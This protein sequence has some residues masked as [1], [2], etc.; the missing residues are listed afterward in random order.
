[1][2]I[3]AG[4]VLQSVACGSFDTRAPLASLDYA[5]DVIAMPAVKDRSALV[6]NEFDQLLKLTNGELIEMCCEALRERE[7]ASLEWR[8]FLKGDPSAEKIFHRQWKRSLA[9]LALG[10]YGFRMPR[11]EMRMHS[12]FATVRDD[13]LLLPWS[14]GARGKFELT[15][16]LP[17]EGQILLEDPLVELKW[18]CAH[19]P[20]RQH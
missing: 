15:G 9:I 1:M 6:R 13:A 7:D 14:R 3:F 19:R 11:R 4:L 10:R 12:P 8:R 5:A 18:L 17:N 20:R 16:S 2:M